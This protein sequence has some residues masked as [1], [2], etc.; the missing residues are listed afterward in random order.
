MDHKCSQGAKPNGRAW[1]QSGYACMGHKDRSAGKGATR[2]R[3]ARIGTQ[4]GMRA[5]R[6]KARCAHM[7]TKWNVRHA[8]TGSK[9]RE[10]ACTDAKRGMCA[11]AA[12]SMTAAHGRKA[13]YMHAGT[14]AQGRMHVRGW[15]KAEYAWGAKIEDKIETD[16]M[17]ICTE[18][19]ESTADNQLSYCRDGYPLQVEHPMCGVRV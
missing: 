10:R 2:A 8:L 16:K 13:G 18:Q 11:Q 17:K 3:D 15:H 19:L 14:W 1:V 6:C 5:Q 4:S 7:G 12:Q 9:R